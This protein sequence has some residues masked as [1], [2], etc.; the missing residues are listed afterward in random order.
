MDI[1][2]LANIFNNDNN[3]IIVLAGEKHINN[4]NNFLLSINS[5]LIYEQKYIYHDIMDIS[6]MIE[7]YSDL[8]SSNSKNYNIDAGV[9]K[10]IC[11]LLPII[12]SQE[13]NINIKTPFFD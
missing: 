4:I 8:V 13:Q 11:G 1:Y 5:N 10:I 3:N 12:N 7:L 6:D 2:I 9:V